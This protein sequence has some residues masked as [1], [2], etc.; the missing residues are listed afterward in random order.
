[1]NPNTSDIHC[2]LLPGVDD[3]FRRSEDSLTA[4]QRM[5]AAGCREIIFTPHMNP[6][7]FTGVTEQQHRDVYAQ[8]RQ[9]IPQEWGLTTHLAAEYMVV[10]GFHD[11]VARQADTLSVFPDRSILIEMSYYYRSR[12]LEQTIFELNMAGLKPILA[13]PE[14]YLYM[15]GTLTDFDRIAE[16]GC[17]MQMNMMSLTGRYGPESM[18]IMDYLLKR[19][20]Y[21]FM[22]TDLHALPQLDQLLAFKPG[23]FMRRRL[24]TLIR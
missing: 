2:H 6:D 22:A 8:F 3:G 5:V 7:V 13:H 17:R 9:L 21:S 12:D 10:N 18:K 15:A 1:M 19:G 14:R 4:M 20:L 11:R 24:R 16:S 23:F